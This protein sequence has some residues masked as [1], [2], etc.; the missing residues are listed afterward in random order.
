M[1][2]KVG[3][4]LSSAV[5]ATSL[6]VVR[7]PEDD[8]TVTCGGAP[9]TGPGETPAAGATAEGEAGNGVLMGKRYSDEALG[10]ELLCVKPGDYAVA[11][12][13]TPLAQKTAQPLPASD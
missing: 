9:M 4:T 1:K 3:Q 10:L 12:N 7:A 6:V 5:D 2:L 13:G 11:V 8:V